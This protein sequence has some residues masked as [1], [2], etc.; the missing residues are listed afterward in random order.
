[1]KQK[2]LESLLK[3]FVLPYLSNFSVKGKLMFMRP[4]DYVLGGFYFDSS[5][6]ESNR[7]TIE[8][9]IQ[10]LYVPKENIVFNIGIRLRNQELN[11]WWTMETENE[12]R[13]MAQILEQIKMDGLPFLQRFDSTM[14]LR[15]ELQ[16]LNSSKKDIRFLEIIAYT[17]ILE[18]NFV[19]AAEEMDQLLNNIANITDRS[20]WVDEMN[21]RVHVMRDAL[22]ESSEKAIELLDSWK[23]LTLEKLKL[24]EPD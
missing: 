15:T 20:P 13:I 22:T 14:K 19:L 12:G 17:L 24:I 8:T 3:Q 18:R 5:H 11:E 6:F 9:F 23:N 7:F 21:K 10:P 4:V 16:R 1:M 2:K